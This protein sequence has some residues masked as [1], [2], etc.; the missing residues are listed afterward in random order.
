LAS[1]LADRDGDICAIAV[2]LK[3]AHKLKLKSSNSKERL[4]RGS[5]S[6]ERFKSAQQRVRDVCLQDT[7]DCRWLKRISGDVVMINPM[8]RITTRR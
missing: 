1:L 5:V 6:Q 7:I 8:G 3:T 4:R 2:P